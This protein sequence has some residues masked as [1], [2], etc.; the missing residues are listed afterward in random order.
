MGQYLSYLKDFGEAR[1]SVRRKVLYNI[2]IE[3]AIR[4]KLIK[5]IIMC[6]NGTYTEVLTCTNLF[7]V[8]PVPNGLKQGNALS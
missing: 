5:L 1:D 3:I 2:F 6:L 4:M 8:F 7:N